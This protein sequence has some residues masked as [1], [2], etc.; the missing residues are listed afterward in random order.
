M[1]VNT[2]VCGWRKYAD[3]VSARE[4]AFRC[5]STNR[6][7]FKDTELETQYATH[8]EL[9]LWRF[10]DLV[11]AICPNISMMIL[12]AFLDSDGVHELRRSPEHRSGY[13]EIQTYSMELRG[14][15]NQG[16]VALFRVALRV[17]ARECACRCSSRNR[18][19]NAIRDA[20]LTLP[21]TSQI[22]VHD[23]RG[24]PEHRS[25]YVEIQTYRMELRG[26][27]NQGGVALFRAARQS[28]C[29]RVCLS[30]FFEKPS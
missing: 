17:I 27:A 11:S 5:S 16:G 29:S 6:G 20:S 10:P 9:S 28:N 13:V 23:S 24:S 15:A 7:P 4:C 22:S 8:R 12:P 30:P 2:H 3:E 21:S 26:E 25:E 19:K 18:V 14:E 1:Y